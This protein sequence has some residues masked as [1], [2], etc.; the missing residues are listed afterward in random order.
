WV[1]ASPPGRR[2]V[3]WYWSVA[4]AVLTALLGCGLGVFLASFRRRG[5]YD[6]VDPKKRVARL[7]ERHFHPTPVA[8]LTVAGRKFPF[9]VRADLQRALDGLFGAQTTIQHFC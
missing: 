6:G 8:D 5:R 3:E 1:G 4:L 2:P 7:L 9:R